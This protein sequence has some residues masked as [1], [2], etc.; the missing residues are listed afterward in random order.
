MLLPG[1]GTAWIQATAFS[2]TTNWTTLPET[3]LIVVFSQLSQPEVAALCRVCTHWNA[4]ARSA[5]LWRDWDFNQIT[6][7][8]L[9]VALST[10]RGQRRFIL[11]GEWMRARGARI[12][13]LRLF[14]C[15]VTWSRATDFSTLVNIGFPPLDTIDAARPLSWHLNSLLNG[16][17]CTRLQKVFFGNIDQIG[18]LTS[19]PVFSA[20]AATIASLTFRF[21]VRRPEFFQP[22]GALLTNLRVLRITSALCGGFG[23][24]LNVLLQASPVLVELHLDE[25]H[26]QPSAAV[27]PKTPYSLSSAS[28]EIF[29]LSGKGFHQLIGLDMPQLRKFSDAENMWSWPQMSWP[30][31]GEGRCEFDFWTQ[32]KYL[33]TVHHHRRFLGGVCFTFPATRGMN[34]ASAPAEESRYLCMCEC[35]ICVAAQ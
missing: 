35:E 8:R 30:G 7:E 18:A 10:R 17:D 9:T 5:V 1:G 12:R 21:R 15:S 20:A 31:N 3:V 25:C 2:Q 34:L 16:V 26:V 33:E 22:P 4:V 23:P 11:Y 14:T 19:M 29:S 13:S 27:H 32:F 24:E 6:S 28:V